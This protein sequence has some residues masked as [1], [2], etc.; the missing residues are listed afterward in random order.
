MTETYNREYWARRLPLIQGFVEGKD[1]RYR[2]IRVSRPRF[3]AAPEDYTLVD[4]KCQM[5][6]EWR[7]VIDV[8]PMR[9][10]YPFAAVDQDGR[11]FLFTDKPWRG[12]Q[13]WLGDGLFC[14]RIHDMS[15][16]DWKCTLYRS[17]SDD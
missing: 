9:D 13:A 3:D 6:K 16:I 15:G 8:H 7:A 4:P 11:I 1:I 10:E 14:G 17:G 2:G 5:P 12:K